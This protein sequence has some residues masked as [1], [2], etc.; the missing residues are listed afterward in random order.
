MSTDTRN[1]DPEL[2]TLLK[3]RRSKTHKAE[4]GKRR[5]RRERRQAKQQG[6][7]ETS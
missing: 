4:A 1:A 3:A 6:H 5:R 7:Q 2:R